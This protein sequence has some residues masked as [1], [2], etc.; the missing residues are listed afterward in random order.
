MEQI[1]NPYSDLKILCHPDKLDAILNSKRTAPLYVRIKPT[2]VCNQNC[3]YCVYA[4]D[5]V[6]EKRSVNRRE[7]IPLNKMKEIITDL[8]DLGTKA[9][10]FSGGGEPLCYP[11]IFDTLRMVQDKGID[12]AM[13]TNGQALEEKARE[14]LA[15]AKWIRISLDSVNQEMYQKMRGVDTFNKVIDNIEKFSKEKNK[16]CVLGINCVVTKNNYKSIYEMC[17][18]V[19]G[20]GVN[21]IKFSPLMVKGEIPQYHR[22]IKAE[23]ETQIKKAID[24]F[25]RDNFMIVDKYTDDESL[26]QNFEKCAQCYVKDIF[27]VIGADCKVYYCHQRAYTESGVIGE[28]SDQSFK[29]LWFSE[30]TTNRFRKMNPREECNFRCAFEERNRLLDSLVNMDRK[31]INFI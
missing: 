1:N 20:I 7:F 19:S 16:E 11:Y 9:I 3:W 8:S 31:H 6:I 5:A 28:L 12:Y 4:N 23:V 13:I 29:E 25:Q 14:A 30:N 2:N 17:H 15:N 21:N 27:T 22:E 10:T 24:D 18:L 26:D